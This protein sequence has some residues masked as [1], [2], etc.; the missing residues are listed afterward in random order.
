MAAALEPI[1]LDA[2][3]AAAKAAI[4]AIYICASEPTDYA[5]A[6]TAQALGNFSFGAGS[7]FG[8]PSNPG[9]FTGRQITS[10]PISAGSITGN[11]TANWWAV[12]GTAALYAHGLLSA[13]QVVTAGN[14][15]TLAAFSIG[16]A[17]Q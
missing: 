8:G 4:A 10:N 14:T 1:F 12:V 3:F 9:G 7:A 13:P 11:G 15:F 17:S 16:M 2:G 6:T 5:S